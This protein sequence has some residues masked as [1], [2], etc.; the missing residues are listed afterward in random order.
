MVRAYDD[1]GNVID[2]VEWE[3]QIRADAIDEV[4]HNLYNCKV[5]CHEDYID[6]VCFSMGVL[7]QLKEQG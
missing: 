4:I 5:N 1:N 2:L 6:G 7:E 3:K